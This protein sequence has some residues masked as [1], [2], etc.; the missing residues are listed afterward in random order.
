MRINAIILFVL[1][2]LT[3]ATY[4]QTKFFIGSDGDYAIL[5][6]ESITPKTSKPESGGYVH[7]YILRQNN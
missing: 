5:I 4:A 3:F 1:M 7:Y 6:G 2:T